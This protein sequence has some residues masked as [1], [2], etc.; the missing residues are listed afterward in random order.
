[1]K[2]LSR[3]ITAD[4]KLGCTAGCRRPAACPW[5]GKIEVPWTGGAGGGPR[6]GAV[7]TDAETDVSLVSS[8]GYFRN[9]FGPEKADPSL[10]QL[11]CLQ[12]ILQETVEAKGD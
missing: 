12:L 10:M 9:I 1:M 5:L 11:R 2:E 4:R 8:F 7:Q 3:L 6:G